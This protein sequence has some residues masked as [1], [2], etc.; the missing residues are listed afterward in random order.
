MLELAYASGLRV[1]ELL[2]LSISQVNLPESLIKI[3]EIRIGKKKFSG[4]KSN[5]WNQPFI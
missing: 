1:S 3:E 5:L 4:K 2:S